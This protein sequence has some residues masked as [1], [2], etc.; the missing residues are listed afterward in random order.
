MTCVQINDVNNALIQEQ[1]ALN[2]TAGKDDMEQDDQLEDTMLAA[3][4]AAV[5]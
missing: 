3:Y 2:V 1:R 4:W 5:K